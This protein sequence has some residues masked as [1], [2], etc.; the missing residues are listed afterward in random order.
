MMVGCRENTHV[1]LP[2]L[3]LNSLLGNNIPSA[4]QNSSGRALGDQRAPLE[5]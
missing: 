3:L 5:R 4:E 1:V 2:S